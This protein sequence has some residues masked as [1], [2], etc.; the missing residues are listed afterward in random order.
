MTPFFPLGVG[1]LWDELQQMQPAGLYWIHADRE[2]DAIQWCRQVIGEQSRESKAALICVGLTP[3][4]VLPPQV[5]VGPVSVP[6]FSLPAHDQALLRLPSDLMRVLKPGGR[7]LILQVAAQTWLD[8][9]QDTL[10]AHWLESM[11]AWLHHQQST[12]L[13]VSHGV[14]AEALYARLHGEHRSLLGLA[15]LCWQQG[16]HS[17]QLAFWRNQ[18]GVSAHQ[19]IHLQPGPQ[20]WQIREDQQASAQFKQDAHLV[21]CQQS[22]LQGG[23]ALS[24]HWQ[25]FADN[26][27]LAK[28]GLATQAATLVFALRYNRDIEAVARKLHRL[29]L[30]C[31]ND[32]KLVVR[33]VS[34][35]LR[36]ADERLLLACG[37]NLV[38]SHHVPLSRFLIQLEGIQ[39]QRFVRQVAADITPVFDALMPLKAKGV[40]KQPHFC[41]VLTELM[42]HPQLSENAKGVLVALQPVEDI[43][44]AQ[45][46]TLC[47]INRMGDLATVANDTLFLFL[48][49][50]NINDVD[51]ALTN[52]FQLPVADLFQHYTTWHQDLPIVTQLQKIQHQQASDWVAPQKVAR[53]QTELLAA[54]DAP[55]RRQPYGICLP[56]F[57]EE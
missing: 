9:K 46:L 54:Q 55:A 21:L 56:L 35:S 31:G 20:G 27:A 30:E 4:E 52:I 25:L 3:D 41:S 13:V 39:G 32:I 7:L 36:Q 24:E 33:E 1:Q 53:R 37:A 17:Y 42:A 45:A 49:S 12:L 11:A 22:V 50:S 14:G 10:L 44:A 23:V 18:R 40:L 47:K 43:K 34:M 28:A 8:S 19:T 26:A 16:C 48:F 51:V 57:G 29:R 15:R 6:L 5:D 2:V 38:V